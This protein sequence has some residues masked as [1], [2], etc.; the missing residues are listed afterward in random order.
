ME[1]VGKGIWREGEQEGK[2][3]RRRGQAAPF[4]VW[5]RPTWLLP[6]NCG[7]GVQTEYQRLGVLLYV[8]DG[9]RIME[10][11][12]HV[13]SLVSR[14]MTNFLLFLAELSAGSLGF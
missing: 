5:F 4:I 8:T 11:R 9:H 13:R 14:G 7:G 10:L 2:R 1:R 3:E 6:S 12:P